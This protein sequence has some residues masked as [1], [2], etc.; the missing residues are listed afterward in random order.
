MSDSIKNE[1]LPDSVSSLGEKEWA[2]FL[3]G[4]MRKFNPKCDFTRGVASVFP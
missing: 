4:S 2:P 1:Y 3:F